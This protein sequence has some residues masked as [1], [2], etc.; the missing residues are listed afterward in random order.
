LSPPFLFVYLGMKEIKIKTEEI[1][2][3]VEFA[4][5]AVLRVGDL[6]DDGRIIMFELVEDGVVV[7]LSW[8]YEGWSVVLDNNGKVIA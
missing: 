7:V 5:G 3:E 6:F 1:I 2:A 8:G 4:D